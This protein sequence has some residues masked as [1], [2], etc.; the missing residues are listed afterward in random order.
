[1]RGPLTQALTALVVVSVLRLA[2]ELLS[3]LELRRQTQRW[4]PRK[5]ANPL[6]H[7][8]KLEVAA[9]VAPPPLPPSRELSPP[10]ARRPQQRPSAAPPAIDLFADAAVA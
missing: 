6:Q 9:A 7:L 4:Q 8:V 2:I 3:R 10:T 1:M 5:P